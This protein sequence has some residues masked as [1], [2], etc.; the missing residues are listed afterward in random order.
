MDDPVRRLR[1]AMVDAI[2][3]EHRLRRQA[4]REEADE[5]RWRQ[6]AEY[7]EERGLIDLAASASARA[8]RHARM[9]SLLRER[10]AQMRTEVERI[11]TAASPTTGAG[12]APP[13]ERSLAARFTYLEID[14][15]LD[16]LRETIR[17]RAAA[18]QTTE[19]PNA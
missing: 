14:A 1:S 15:E 9:A 19:P 5:E 11:R 10:A 8:A 4:L 18:P 12:R 6:R 13:A 2:A 16:R 17:G 7:A 3:G